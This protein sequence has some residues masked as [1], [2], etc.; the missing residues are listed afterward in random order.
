MTTYIVTITHPS[1]V[2]LYQAYK[3]YAWVGV[4]LN[5]SSYSVRDLVRR[6]ES[7]GYTVYFD[8][9]ARQA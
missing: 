2:P 4:Y 6:L 9:A 8:I 1:R 5:Q 3:M 7:V